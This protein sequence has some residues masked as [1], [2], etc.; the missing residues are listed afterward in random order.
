MRFGSPIETSHRLMMTVFRA[1]VNKA[2]DK[3]M[4]Q[5]ASLDSFYKH[6]REGVESP[7]NYGFSSVVLPRDK[8]QQ[9]Q[10]QASA[11]QDEDDQQGEAAEATVVAAGAGAHWVAVV[12]DDRRHR[13]RLLP[14][15]AS[16]QYGP[17]GYP[18]KTKGRSASYIK[19]DKGAYL[20][21]P[22]EMASL[23]HVNLK[24]Q[25]RPKTQAN[26]Q[27]QGQAQQ[28]EEYKHEGD[29]VNTEVRCTK[30]RIEFRIGDEVVA[31]ID[32]TSRRFVTM[33]ET[34]LGDENADHPVYGKEGAVGKVTVQ[35]GPGAVLVKATMPGP[36]TS[37]DTAP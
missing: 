19:P 5:D 31:Y 4:M 24:K 30:N 29:S 35:S 21:S 33:I 10:Q 15:G 1:T 28:E 23:R 36:P 22:Y 18:D 32:A 26:A 7:Q 14:E 17:N 27:G 16:I 20:L 37:L 12:M 11:G 3:P 25:E 13:P 34:R 9:K 2:N 8:K 6:K